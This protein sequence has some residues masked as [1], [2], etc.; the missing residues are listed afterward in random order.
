LCR[1]DLAWAQAYEGD[2][3]GAIAAFKSLIAECEVDHDEF[4]KPA[5]L[6]GLGV[7]LAQQ[8]EVDAARAAADVAFETASGMDDYF[9][10][11]GH[12]AAALAAL[13]ADDVSAAREASDRAWQLLSLGQPEMAAVQRAFNTVEVALAE[14]DLV[15]ARDLADEAVAVATGG[16]RVTALLARARVANTEGDREGA[17]RDAHDALACA[18]NCGAYQPLAGILECLAHLAA[19][20]DGRQAARLFGAAEALRQRTG[21]VRFKVHQA[22]YESSVASLRDAMEDKDFEAAW[23][24]GAALSTEDAIAYARRGRGERKR[25]AT[26]WAS[27]TPAEHEVVRLVCDGLVTKEI[28]GRLFVSPRTVHAHLTHIY[29][30]L[31]VNSRVQLMQEAA[32]RAE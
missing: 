4:L 14:G 10:G 22:G 2:L 26:G 15:Q 16:H 25:P 7:A 3:N 28:G 29:T 27:L 9:Q 1:F 20:V 13:A 6:M 30:K 8:G 32:R 5:C 21:M 24:E 18:T 23:A 17:E 19:D 11:M 12:A 31:G